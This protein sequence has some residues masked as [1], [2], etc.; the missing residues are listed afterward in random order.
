[1]SAGNIVDADSSFVSAEKKFVKAKDSFV[2]DSG[3]YVKAKGN[4]ETAIGNY[5][6]AK[7]NYENA[8][9]SC[10]VAKRNYTV[11]SPNITE[12]RR[13]S[14]PDKIK[15]TLSAGYLYIIVCLT[16]LVFTVFKLQFAN[17]FVLRTCSTVNGLNIFLNVQRCIHQTG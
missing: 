16:K 5:V 6:N 13:K 2:K 7:R 11:S 1:V 10:N 17:L 8:N 14:E 3:N 9:G 12:D 4:I 15:S